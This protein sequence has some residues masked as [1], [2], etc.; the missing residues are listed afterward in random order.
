MNKQHPPNRFNLYC[1]ESCH[2]EHD[3]IPVMTLGCVWCP[4]ERAVVFARRLR[5]IKAAHGLVSPQE[6]KTGGTDKVFE[7]K[8]SKVSQAKA[9][10][11]LDWIKAFFDEPELRFR[12]LVIPDKTKLE[13]DQFEQDHDQWYYKMMYLLIDRV[14]NP[15]YKY[16]VFLDIKDTRSEVRRAKLEEVLRSR[17]RDAAGQVIERV[18]Q[19]R[20]HESELLQL[21]DL[22]L[23]AIGYQNRRTVGDLQDTPGNAGKEEVIKVIQRRAKKSLTATTWQGET[24][25]NIL[26][27]EPRSGGWL[28]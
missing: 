14:I 2:L 9:S 16:R 22:I 11:Y 25:L 13:H 7:V 3:N 18:Q 17:A 4:T 24:K 15:R 6:Y 8:W 10:F 26:V 19:I 28:A 21:S 20:S 27:W 23:G 12:G 5:E 1:D